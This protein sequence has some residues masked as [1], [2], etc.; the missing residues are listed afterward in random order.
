VTVDGEAS[1]GYHAQVRAVSRIFT[2][3]TLLGILAGVVLLLRSGIRDVSVGEDFETYAL[4]RDGSRLAASSPVVIAGVRVGDIERVSLEGGLARVD[5]R[6]RNDIR[7]A[8]TSV[9]T[10]RADK[11]FGDSYV[12]IIP[13]GD[14]NA[15]TLL[16][17]Q[18]ILHVLEGSSAD[19][20]LR[21]IDAA[22]PKA[23]HAMA[24]TQQVA[25]ESRQW[26][27]GPFADGLMRS[28]SW[29]DD[30]K[31]QAPIAAIDRGVTTLDDATLRIARTLEESGPSLLPGLDRINRAIVDARE[32]M[33]SATTAVDGLAA[34]TEEGLAKIDPV[35]AEV[36]QALRE[37]DEPGSDQGTLARLVNDVE[38]ADDLDDAAATGAEFLRNSNRFK[39]LLG[40]RAEYN[41]FSG[42]Q[43]FY[44]A[45]EVSAHPDSFYFFEIERG[46]QG[47]QPEVAL[48]NARAAGYARTT[49]IS[50]GTKFSAQYGKR[51]GPLSLRAGIMES[52][53]GMGTDVQLGSRLRLSANLFGSS[54]AS[55]P[56]LKLVGAFAVF[57]SLYIFAGVDDALTAAGEV[58]IL[59][60]N[61]TAPTTLDRLRYG[62]DL[63]LGATLV[64][65]EEDLA[66]LLRVYGALLAGFL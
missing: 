8:K 19:T 31:L 21:G 54:F 58:P 45:A 16:S 40:M 46:S 39:V 33:R 57:R 37:I 9:A 17:G 41:V 12:E 18:R 27:G 1:A 28:Q 5:L 7:V 6:L 62:R 26:I 14:A 22:L 48:S 10:R 56:Q 64:F 24:L 66:M 44:V 51:L 2:G 53:I 13:T 15:E 32:D 11:L 65:S 59:S 3:L 43:R 38:L 55:P 52:T 35:V 29:L 63:F 61:V 36:S 49:T 30:G 4:F 47:G 42:A 23:D 25:I 20:I 50:S 60:G 34:A